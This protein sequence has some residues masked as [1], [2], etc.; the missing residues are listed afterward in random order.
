LKIVVLTRCLCLCLAMASLPASAAEAQPT[1]ALPDPVTRI[2]AALAVPKQAISLWVQDV[3]EPGP[4]AAF[5]ADVAR[6]PASTMKL[7]TTFAALERLGP[8]YTWKTEVYLA[9]PPSDGL[10]A[11]DV[12]LRGYGDPYLVNEEVWKIAT[13]LWQA[14]IRRI[15][16]DLVFDTSYFDLPREDRGAFDNQ[17]DRVYNLSPH[18]LLVNFNAVTVKVKPGADGRS[19]DVSADPPLPNLHLENRL[20]LRHSRC[21][22][23][24]RGVALA[25]RDPNRRDQLLLEGQFPT[26]CTE[27]ELT[28]TVLQP[29]SYAY[30][31]FDLYWRQ[32]GGELK[33]QWRRGTIPPGVSTPFYA[34]H[35][36]PLGDLVRLVNKYSNNVM[37]R[38]LELTLGA[39]RFGPPATPEKGQRAIVEV[40]GDRGIDTEGLDIS[41]SAGLS[42]DVRISARQL[43]QVLAAAWR[44]PYM[45]EFVSSLA[46]AG[47]DGTLRSRFRGTAEEGR[48]HLKTG[49]L[50]DVSSIAGYVTTPSG[51]RLM[52]VLMVN[53]PGAHRGP[54]QELQDG[55]LR[56]AYRR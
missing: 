12:W 31:L 17:P 14:G 36:R 54:G 44:S 47:L 4:M 51:R 49:T 39:E 21:T 18:P 45:P 38:H 24:Q 22:G 6:N 41:N 29:E 1:E 10:V 33:G 2:A 20:N 32:I 56:W 15:E 19:V 11:G 43:G 13:A 27:Y 23:F 50:D 48:M 42:R 8:A 37:T 40:L 34:H 26:A 16:G 30:G 7:V 53:A 28:R 5:N 9:A 35:S 46:M 3:A 25:V 55:L 52:V